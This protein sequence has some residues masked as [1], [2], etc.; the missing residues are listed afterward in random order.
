VIKVLMIFGIVLSV[1]CG[2]LQPVEN[3]KSSGCE[4]GTALIAVY[5]GSMQTLCGCSEGSGSKSQN[6]TLLTCT[7]TKPNV[8]V[9]QFIGTKNRHQIVSADF[10]GSTLHDPASASTTQSHAVKL[11]TAGSYGFHD[12][13]LPVIGGTIVVQ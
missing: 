9:F 7:V 6:G 11:E 5:D 12:G 13:F 10:I 3:E 8:V 1:G 2:N 4:S